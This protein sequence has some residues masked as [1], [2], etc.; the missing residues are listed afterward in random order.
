MPKPIGLWK[1]H[2]INKGKD[3]FTDFSEFSADGRRMMQ[4]KN[5]AGPRR[6]FQRC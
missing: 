1:M 4:Q 2:W 5:E 6:P 3:T